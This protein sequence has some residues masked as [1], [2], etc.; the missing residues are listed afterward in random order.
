MLTHKNPAQLSLGRKPSGYT[1]GQLVVAYRT[2][3]K[4]ASVAKLTGDINNI[5]V[6]YLQALEKEL[7]H[8]KIDIN[9]PEL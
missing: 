3:L 6:R 7:K 8:R 1:N 4:A 5:N 2:V 9:H